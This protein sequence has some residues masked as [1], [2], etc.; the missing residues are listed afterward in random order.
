[1]AIVIE[2]LSECHICHKLL[3]KSK[4]FILLPPLISNMKDDLFHLSDSGI[5]VECLNRSELKEKLTKHVNAY[6]EH[7]PLT[8]L[9]CIVDGRTIDDPRNLLFLGL[10][11][12]DETESLHEFN[13]ITVN[14]MNIKIWTDYDRFVH[15]ASAFLSD[16]KWQSFGD[17]NELKYVLEMVT[18]LRK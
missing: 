3:N 15:L 1:M 18:S 10:L 7:M 13:Y 5:H 2:N 12:S 4:P 16:G 8:K 17:F 11:T 14:L 9:K 6:Q